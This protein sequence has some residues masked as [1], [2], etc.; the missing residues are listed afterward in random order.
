[1]I[2][3][4]PVFLASDN[5]YAPFVATTI[6]SIV[7][8]TKSFVDFY[9]LDGGI[10][11]K[12][13]QKIESLK[14]QFNNFAIEFL[15]MSDAQLERFP[16]VQ[17]YSVNAFSRYFIPELKPE[18]NKI[19]YLD[20]DIIVKGDIAKLYGQNL[21]NYPLGAVL[22]DFYEGNYV[23]LK[24]I[25]PTYSGG[26]NYFNSGVLVMDL[27]YFRKN[28]LTQKLIDKTIELKEV[29]SCPDQDIFNFIFEG[30]FKILDY[31]FNFMPDHF[32]LLKKMHPEKA[33]Q[34]KNNA[35]IFHYTWK[36]PWLNKSVASADFWEIAKL[37]AFYEG[38]LSQLKRQLIKNKMKCFLY[39][40]FSKLTF[41][42]T[43]EKYQQRAL[44]FR[45]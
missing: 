29:L 20:V 39:I 1:M 36:K 21:E 11:K 5:N 25:C 26:S 42:K 17:H 27:D 43:R 4:I 28:N 41:G 7:K 19:L 24:K 8:N 38:S 44:I 2:E 40:I 22:E 16:N 10:S 6:C 45:F 32:E 3:N 14:N 35:I 23:H 18:L 9:V 13:K 37:T 12:N 31:E 30:N 34:I 33:E 15:D